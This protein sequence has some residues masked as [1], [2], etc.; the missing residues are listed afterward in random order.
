MGGGHESQELSVETTAASSQTTDKGASSHTL[1]ETMASSHVHEKKGAKTYVKEKKRPKGGAMLA[2]TAEG[3]SE[4]EAEASLLLHMDRTLQVYARRR[5]MITE[6]RRQAN[7]VALPRVMIGHFE[8]L[9]C[10]AMHSVRVRLLLGTHVQDV[11]EW[12]GATIT[13]PAHWVKKMWVAGCTIMAGLG[14]RAC[15]GYADCR[16]NIYLIG[17]P[18]EDRKNKKGAWSKSALV[19]A[20][21]VGW[22]LHRT[23][24]EGDCS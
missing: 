12:F 3:G 17:V 11:W 4:E 16:L 23:V 20:A 1:G 10:A 6:I 22:H 13:P 18:L 8:F 14:V 2:D 5:S 9:D 24:A 7:E 19:Q 21:R 15:D